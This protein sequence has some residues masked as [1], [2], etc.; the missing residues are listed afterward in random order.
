MFCLQS[1][2]FLVSICCYI[3]QLEPSRYIGECTLYNRKWERGRL[4]LLLQLAGSDA[5]DAVCTSSRERCQSRGRK[6]ASR[7]R[8]RES[9]DFLETII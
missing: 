3:R 8:E 2:L 6:F 1:I 4:A 9:D 5:S 7:E